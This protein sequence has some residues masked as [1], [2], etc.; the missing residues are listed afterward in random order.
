M[1]KSLTELRPKLSESDTV[2]LN[3]QTV[4]CL[5]LLRDAKILTFKLSRISKSNGGSR[6][7][8]RET[9][10]KFGTDCHCMYLN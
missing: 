6:W 8:K 9:Y 7:K 2:E 10:E 3:V 4:A 5:P 1:P